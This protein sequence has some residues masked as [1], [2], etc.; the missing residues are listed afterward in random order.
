MNQKS[1]F[2]GVDF[3][4]VYTSDRTHNE[5][6]CL[7]VI[8][9][10]KEITKVDSNPLLEIEPNQIEI[11]GGTRTKTATIKW[12]KRA[13]KA[14]SEGEASS[15]LLDTAE[16]EYL[17]KNLKKPSFCLAIRSTR[18]DFSQYSIR[19]LSSPGRPL[20][21]FDPILSEDHFRFRVDCE[22]AFDCKTQSQAP[23]KVYKDP[24]IDYMARDYAS[25]RQS[26][27]DRLSLIIPDWKERNPAEFGIAM[28]ELMAYI[29]DHLSYYQDAVATEAYL[30][31]ARRRVSV[32]RHARLLDYF[33][34]EG[35]NSRAW[36]HLKVAEAV[37]GPNGATYVPAK[38]K[39]LTSGKIGPVIVKPED[40]KDALLEEPEVF[41]TMQAGIISCCPTISS[42]FISL[43]T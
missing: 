38:T 13:D 28:V 4:E 21:G 40:L 10:F 11:T 36:I 19:L 12:V 2:N 42:T 27:L 34:H 24:D 3:V 30:G 35:C 31:M 32:K 16:L 22:S 6:S 43:Q 7:I 33:V 23:A 39:L 37:L 41:E 20:E 9:C 14:I 26:L 18:G 29:G 25:L 17:K 15:E 5:D 8:V 1:K